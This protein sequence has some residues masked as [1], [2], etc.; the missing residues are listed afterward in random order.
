M[1]TMIPLE[2]SVPVCNL[3]VFR[4]KS[5]SFS[6]KP[7][8]KMKQTTYAL[9]LVLCLMLLGNQAFAQ[10]K[11]S[12]GFRQNWN[13]YQTI[14]DSDNFDLAD[15]YRTTTGRGIEIAYYNRLFKNTYLAVPFKLGVARIPIK[16]R[17]FQ[18][19][20]IITNLDLLLQHNLFKH[21]N[22]FNPYLHAGIGSLYNFG[23]QDFGVNFPVGIGLNIRLAENVY[24]SGQTQYRFSTNDQDGWHNAVGLHVFFGQKEEVPP[25]PPPAPTDRDGDGIADTDDKC[26]DQAGL[27]AFGGCPDTDGDGIA[28]MNDD[29]PAEK[30]IAAFKGCPDTDNDGIADKTDKCP[31]EAGP[32]SNAGCPV[33]DTDKDGIADAE[34][35]CP[36]EAGPKSTMGCP[37]RDND[38]V[39]DREDACPDK[40]GDS[41]HK[42]CPDTDKDGT[43][44]DEDRCVDKPGPASNKGCPEIKKEDKEKLAN[45]VKNVQFELGKATLLAKS[46]PVLDEIAGLMQ[47]YPEY[48]LSISGHT[49]NVGDD[50]VNQDLSE[51]RA[52]A[53]FDYLTG[54]GIAAAR[55]SHSGFGKTKPI[56]DNKT[57]AGRDLN[58][59]VDFELTVK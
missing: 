29:C 3:C 12:L 7:F 35:K 13:N 25:P 37:D 22:L 8:V 26:P 6:T 54:K 57:K 51:R 11:H 48:S 44:D 21:G 1:H 2:Q 38:G 32:A 23:E 18:Q 43:Y 49:D 19:D 50:K 47:K 42:G 39:A 33:L 15:V 41:L 46:F 53:C 10:P 58:R 40:K 30:G 56:A 20:D 27:A 59:R 5:D 17:K 31:R 9:F 45:V 52:K 55:M 14:L 36:R 34:D 16:D 4:A 28:D 24:A